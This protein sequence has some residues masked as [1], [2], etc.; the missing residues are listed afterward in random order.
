LVIFT[1][2]RFTPPA[3]ADAKAPRSEFSAERAFK[4]LEIIAQQ[5]HPIGSVKHAEVRDYLVTQLTLLGLKPEVQSTN[6]ASDMWGTIQGAHVE[7]ILARIPGH[8]STKAIALFAHYDSVPESRGANDDG[9]GVVTL[10]ET[11]RALIE[12]GRLAND[13]IM[14]F[15]DAEENGLLGAR[16][17][18]DKHPWAHDIELF[19]N[20]EARGN[21]GPST[22]FRSSPHNGFLIPSFAR[23]V[24]FP[25]TSSLLSS[26]SMVLPNDT[27]FTVL[28]KFGIPGYDFA[29]AAGL[30]RYHTYHDSVETL[31]L[32]SLQHHGSNALALTRYLGNVDLTVRPKTMDLVYFDL[33]Q[34]IVVYYPELLGSLLGIINLILFCLLFWKTNK[35]LRSTAINVLAIF[36][37][38]LS[39]FVLKFIFSFFKDDAFFVSYSAAMIWP[40]LLV[41]FAIFQAIYIIFDKKLA[42]S[43]AFAGAHLPWIT[44][45]LITGIFL[46]GTSYI[47]HWPVLF[48]L[49]VYLIQQR[50]FAHFRVLQFIAVA[51]ACVLV[52]RLCFTIF[53][54]EGGN[55][56]AATAFAL[57]ILLSFLVHLFGDVPRF[58]QKR[59]ALCTFTGGFAVLVLVVSTVHHTEF[60]PL[61]TSLNYALDADIG[62]ASFI[63]DSHT[64]E[65]WPKS[66]LTF[67]EMS[68]IPAFFS[69]K[70][71]T[72][73]G[74]APLIAYP[75][76]ELEVLANRIDP[77][78]GLQIVKLRLASRRQA[79]CIAVWEESPST[80]KAMWVNDERIDSVVRF[81]QTIDKYAA[82][83]I[84]GTPLRAWELRYCNIPQ[85]G[86]TV[87]VHLETTHPSLRLR[88]VD[89]SYGLAVPFPP[90]TPDTI[91]T[92][93]SNRILVS[94]SY[95]FEIEALR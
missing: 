3:P 72:W 15:T 48:S 79:P 45:G 86:I 23:A 95:T 38:S 54:L 49:L 62:A 10:L 9:S 51:P 13:V 58:W 42:P 57:G 1:L 2:Y 56:P 21:H 59:L 61:P 39:V 83:T 16:A 30:D 19:L 24:P 46:P 37:G 5:P 35:L 8:K 92:P 12:N 18:V 60:H 50:H 44:L 36:T 22:M 94:K 47:F 89:E 27:D 66:M 53:V 74:P 41:S 88:L 33:F 32:R 87:E 28:T 76:P 29:Y 55:A 7:N 71:K 90:R 75:A 80:L 25:V 73:Q 91:P 64:E 26:L 34:W 40:F 43:E 65:Y 68:S 93:F 20:F 52:S 63:T 84:F 17:F 70:N 78:S 6:V 4:H 11:A 31:D 81:S 69:R 85:T 82:D 67:R 77:L 14:V